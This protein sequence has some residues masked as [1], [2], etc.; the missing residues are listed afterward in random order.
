MEEI[1]IFENPAFGKIRTAGTSEEPLFCLADVCKILEIGNTSDVAKRLDTPYLCSIE[2]GVVTGKK[3][4]GTDAVQ[5]VPMIFMGESNLY[6]CI[7]QSRKQQ[8]KAFQDWVCGEVLPTIRKTGAENQ[9]VMVYETNGDAHMKMTSLQIAEVTGMRHADVMRAIRNMEPAWQKVSQR[10]FAL[11]SYKQQLP[12]GGEKDVPCYLLD[13]TECLYIATKFNDE[14]RARLVLR[15]EELE[16]ESR[17]NGMTIPN[18]ANPAEAAR[19]WAEQ[20]EKALALKAKVEEDAPKV[21]FFDAVAESKTALEMKAVANVLHFKGVGRNKLFD[22]LRTEKV[23]MGN[24]MPYQ[25]YVDGGMFRTVE[26]KYTTP[27]GEVRISIKTLVYQKGVDFIRKMLTG[28]GYRE[29]ERRGWEI[30]P[31]WASL[32]LSK[33]WGDRAN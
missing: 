26:Q 7:F 32:S 11:S 27:D 4:D 5:N 31:C 23:L 30:R 8:A 15:W 1:R 25:R 19:A 6:R 18:F 2:V 12:N 33:P 22:I 3:A 20:Y 29:A 28:R 17:K 21:E 10:N 9:T 16:M 14:A 24:N 13:K